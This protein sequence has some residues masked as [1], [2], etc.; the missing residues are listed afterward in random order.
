MKKT[1]LM[2]AVFACTSAMAQESAIP[3][4]EVSMYDSPNI[5][6]KVAKEHPYDVEFK[7]EKQA[8]GQFVMLTSMQLHGGSFYVS[9]NSKTDFKGRFRI[10][11]APNDDLSIGLF[12]ETP[13]SVEVVDPHRFVNGPINWVTEDTKYEHQLKVHSKEDFTI[14][15]KI[16]FVIEPKCTLEEIPL[17]FKYKSGVLTVEPWE[18]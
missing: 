15:G 5:D 4:L 10:E 12:E 13:A 14:G 11:V 2:I 9:P 7:V 1:L 6:H 3:V 8:D 17:M 16:I 18:C